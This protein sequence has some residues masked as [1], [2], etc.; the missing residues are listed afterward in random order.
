MVEAL[1][2]FL[3]ESHARWLI[4]ILVFE[5]IVAVT[6]SPT[7]LTDYVLAQYFVDKMSFLNAVHAF[8]GEVRHPEAV[9]FFIAL[10]FVLLIPKAVAWYAFLKNTPYSQLAQFVITP[11]SKY[12]PNRTLGLFEMPT[13]EQA[14]QIFT[15]ERS[16]FS[17]IIWSLLSLLLSIGI[18]WYT[19]DMNPDHD[20]NGLLLKEKTALINAGG[21][22][23]WF[24]ISFAYV[25]MA[26]LM[27][28]VIYF[29]CR[30]YCR[31][32]NELV[33]KVKSLFR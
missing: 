18:L 4:Y 31:F 7:I 11:Y 10:S 14:K 32:F 8:D 33:Y 6:L 27:M 16:M 15:I 30:D 24:V 13:E 22:Y 25:A 1:R 5:C 9:S 26:S 12:K 17:R 20:R 19:A 23:I 3:L 28:S 21:I 29:I 2:Y